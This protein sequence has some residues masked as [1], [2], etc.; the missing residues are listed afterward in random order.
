MSGKPVIVWFTNDLRLCDNAALTRAAASGR[1]IVP[2]FVLDEH[3]PGDR[4]MGAAS[5]W[6][7]ER[8]LKS[9]SASISA[10]NGNL[11][12]RRG[13]TVQALQ[14]LIDETGAGA[15]YFSRNHAP[16]SGSL[17]QRVASMCEG[18]SVECKRFAGFLMH[19]PASTLTGGGGPYKVYSPFSRKCFAT[20]SPREPY[21]VPA[22]LSFSTDEI[23]TDNLQAWALYTAIPDWAHQFESRWQP[24]EA[25]ARDKLARFLEQPVQHYGTARNFPAEFATSRLSPHLHFGEVSPLQVWHACTHVMAASGARA[26]EG[27]QVFLKEILWREFSYHLLHHWP[28]LP[29]QPFKREFADFPWQS[30]SVLLQAWQQGQTG[31]PIVDAGM[32]ELW[33]T[34]WMHNRV[35]MI[36]A[37]LLVKNLRIHWREGE[38]WF[39]DTLVDA[40]IGANAAS[41]Q[42][43]SGCG[44]D[45]AP[46]FRIFNPVLQ[47]EKFDPDGT[48]VRKWVPELNDM[49]AKYIHKPWLAPESALTKAAVEL[50]KSY[51]RPI[52]DLGKT[53]DAALDAYKTIR[54]SE[55]AA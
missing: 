17:E 54:K 20:L 10:S 52:V 19:D 6:W 3:T 34:G 40:D 28:E 46:Y 26:D 2:V 30:S 53:R 31:I 18:K 43:V 55:T 41:W 11:V 51:P 50:G 48:Y 45:A 5:H 16:W 38:R 9:L 8:S 49:H 13:E 7:L 24:G 27:G 14:A 4:V 42:W 39:W 23:A 12:L 21:S 25:G 36:V 44:A 15:V 37:S 47:G 35:R 33:A 1:P 29:S 22:R 32:R